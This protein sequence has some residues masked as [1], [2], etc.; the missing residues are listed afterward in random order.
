MPD[1]KH[2]ES[3]NEFVSRFMSSGEAKKSFP[4]SEEEEDERVNQED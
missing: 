2:K 1:P 4:T 3:R